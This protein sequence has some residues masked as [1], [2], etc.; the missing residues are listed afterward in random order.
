M[1]REQ[2]QILRRLITSE[3][4]LYFRHGGIETPQYRE[5]RIRLFERTVQKLKE[6][7]NGQDT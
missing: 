2:F 5:Q 3:R 4:R 1:T 6:G 7:I